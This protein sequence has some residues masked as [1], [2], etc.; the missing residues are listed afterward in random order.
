MVR[1]YILARTASDA[2]SKPRTCWG[3]PTAA[4][5]PGVATDAL[6]ARA[7]R[8]T[9]PTIANS[10]LRS[11]RLPLDPTERI[12]TATCGSSAPA[13]LEIG[14]PVSTSLCDR[15][16]GSWFLGTTPKGPSN[17]PS[18]RQAAAQSS[19]LAAD[20]CS[21][22]LNL[23]TCARVGHRRGGQGDESSR[24]A[25]TD[26]TAVGGRRAGAAGRRNEGARERRKAPCRRRPRRS[27]GARSA[28]TSSSGKAANQRKGDPHSRGFQAPLHLRVLRS[29][30][31][32]AERHR[33][34][35]DVPF[36]SGSSR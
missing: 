36:A 31:S 34:Q 13:P 29:Q 10:L 9:S 14:I 24:S 17:T 25:R 5:G 19:A 6:S 27:A 16:R 21:V 20:S 15:F 22:V 4:T 18:S 30:P 26:V 23:L 32:E 33:Q 3:T 35:A 2:L 11:L 28:R 12:A 8:S 1:T 7:E